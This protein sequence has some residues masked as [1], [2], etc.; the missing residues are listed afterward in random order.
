MGQPL[1]IAE[2]KIRFV[3]PA[4]WSDREYDAALRVIEDLD[5]AAVADRAVRNALTTRQALDGVRIV[6]TDG[7][8]TS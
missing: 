7:R 8:N 4:G 1:D 2:V 6:T 3:P 5:L